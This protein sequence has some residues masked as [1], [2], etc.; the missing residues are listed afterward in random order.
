MYCPHVL[1]LTALSRVNP[2]LTSALRLHIFFSRSVIMHHI[3]D[4]KSAYL[5]CYFNIEWVLLEVTIDF[6]YELKLVFYSIYSHVQFIYTY[7][8]LPAYNVFSFCPCTLL[9]PPHFEHAYKTTSHSVIFFFCSCSSR[10]D[11]IILKNLV[12]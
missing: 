6:V 10:C 4:K 12:N 2:V 9:A 11:Y 5:F 1:G 8:N 3:L 7:G